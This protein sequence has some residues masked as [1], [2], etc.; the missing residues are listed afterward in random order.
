MHNIGG[1]DIVCSFEDVGIITKSATDGKGE[2]VER[3][4]MYGW[5]SSPAK[6]DDGE[7]VL[8]EGLDVRPLLKKGVI[9]WNHRQ[10]PDGII[11]VPLVAELRDRPNF[12]KCLYTE[13]ELSPTQPLGPPTW[14]LAKSLESMGRSLGLSLEGK[15]MELSPGGAVKKAAIWNIAVTANPKNDYAPVRSLLKGIVEDDPGIPKEVFEPPMYDA[16]GSSI[17]KF[18]DAMTTAMR[19]AIGAGTDVGGSSQAGGGAF[20]REA[21]DGETIV[22]LIPFDTDKECK[23]LAGKSSDLLKI[24][25]SF[26]RMA[27]AN[28]GYLTRFDSAVYLHLVTGADFDKCMCLMNIQEDM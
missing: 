20:R 19:K 24:C 15:R 28:N 8:Q 21:M 14:R 6:D 4:L 9:N 25:Q 23:R 5:A 26:G 12:G 10:D 18:I 3:M 1:A 17:D 7:R 11:G 2:E 13:L 27:K 22:A 16:Y